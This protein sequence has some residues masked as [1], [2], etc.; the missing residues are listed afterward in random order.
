[1]AASRH[2]TTPF[3]QAIL[4]LVC[5]HYFS[6][7][8]HALG[9]WTCIV[10]ALALLAGCGTDW[11]ARRIRIWFNNNYDRFGISGAGGSGAGGPPRSQ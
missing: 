9:R 1:M 11:T 5:R 6:F 2:L 10:S 3:E 4:E 7:P 8:A